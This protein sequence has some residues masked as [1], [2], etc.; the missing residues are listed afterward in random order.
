MDTPLFRRS[1]IEKHYS[2][3]DLV[4]LEYAR[5][6]LRGHP[7]LT[8][9]EHGQSMAAILAPTICLVT[10]SSTV[11]LDCFFPSFSFHNWNEQDAGHP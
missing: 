9:K 4:F 1:N 3:Y 8:I 7:L 10:H 11:A 2:P 5:H 6:D